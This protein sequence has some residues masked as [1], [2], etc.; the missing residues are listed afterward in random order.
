MGLQQILL[1]KKSGRDFKQVVAEIASICEG[2]ISAE[3]TA[4]DTDGMVQQALEL[5]NELP[6]NVII[7]I[8]CIQKG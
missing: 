6:E 7:K 5:K 2:P 4:M 8:P 1:I 3:V